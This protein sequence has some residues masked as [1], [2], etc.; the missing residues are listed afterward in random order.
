MTPQSKALC[1][2]LQDHFP[3]HLARLKF[4]SLFIL[5]VL[6]LTTVNMKKLSNALNGKAKR[7]S[8]YRRLQRFFKEF[9]LDQH[10][11]AKLLLSL[12]PESGPYMVSIDRT[13]WKLGQC[14]INILM[15]GIVYQG[16]CL[17]LAWS[18]LDK[19]GNSNTEERITLMKKL[20]K[21]LSKDQI[22]CVVADREFI[23][24]SWFTYLE[25]E[26]LFYAIRIKENALVKGTK[27]DRPVKTLFADLAIDE[28]RYLR[29]PRKIYGHI[30]YLSVLR[31]ADELLIVAS[32]RKDSN[33]LQSYK[34]RW[35]IEVLFAAFKSRGFDLEQTHLTKQ[36]RLEKLI[37]LLS[38]AMLWALLVGTWE[39]F[40]QPI[41]V[42]KHGRKEKSLFRL[43]LD[44]LQYVLLNIK[45]Q[46]NDFYL[47]LNLMMAP[48][49]ENK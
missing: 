21:V 39:S 32:H 11:I 14:N 35:G 36:E 45:D 37:C 24:D 49:P 38:L 18:L 40:H 17:P 33:A 41:V 1:A 2:T 10:Q 25:D 26:G 43:G 29:K 27:G 8:N 6:Q 5:A 47:Y 44:Q 16:I 31:L 13:N 34:R 30:L 46:W 12:V 3:W 4:V 9:D 23:G 20:V 19:R 42:K 22:K 7:D 15:A 48:R 28:E